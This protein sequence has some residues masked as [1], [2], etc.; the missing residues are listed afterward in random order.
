MRWLLVLLIMLISPIVVR[1]QYLS[2]WSDRQFVDFC[3]LKSPKSVESLN[4]QRHRVVGQAYL[5]GGALRIRPLG[6]PAEI[7][8]D[9]CC[10][11]TREHTLSRIRKS[12]SGRVLVDVEATV[13]S[14]QQSQKFDDD[15][16]PP[17]WNS[18]GVYL[19]TMTPEQR[20]IETLEY[21]REMGKVRAVREV[22]LWRIGE[23]KPFLTKS[24]LRVLGVTR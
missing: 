10:E 5:Q 17:Y 12:D 15:F 1:A 13:Y 3:K 8:L 7:E 24:Q 11:W 9:Y 18:R 6:C 14:V 16:Q 2:K 21:A 20:A 22:R 23:A 4:G 19:S